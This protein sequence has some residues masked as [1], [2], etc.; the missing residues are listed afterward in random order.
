MLP[1]VPEPC[2]CGD[3]CCPSCFPGHRGCEEC[4]RYGQGAQDPDEAYERWRD[5][6]DEEDR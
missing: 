2:L 1:N 4:G 6:R 3:P 5:L